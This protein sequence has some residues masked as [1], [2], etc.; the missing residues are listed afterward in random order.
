MEKKDYYD[1]L[2]LAHS[3]TKDDIKKAYRKLA[4]KYHPDKNKEKGA[5]EKFKEIS[6]AY[7]V[8]YDDEKRKMYDQYGHKGIDQQY[9]K[10][11]IF[12]TTD[13]GD[14]FR[15]TGFDFNDIFQQFFGQRNGFTQRQRPQRGSDIRYDIEI[16]LE[17]AYKGMETEL[18]VPRTELCDTCRGSGARPGSS[19]KRCP[20]CGGSGQ[21]QTSRRTAFGM[22]TQ[23]N[24]CPKCHGQGTFIEDPCPSCRGRGTQQKTRKIELRI[25]K[26]IED[27]A[28][29]RLTGQGEH[30]KGAVQ[31]GDLYVVV[32][33]KQHA[34][35]ERREADLYRKLDIS[36]PQASLGATLSVE[37]L[38]DS[39]TLKI[40]EGT[41]NGTI[42]KI[43][44]SGMPKIQGSG[45]GD[46]YVLIQV[47]T[48]KK[49]SKRAKLLLEE[50]RRELEY[51]DE[52]YK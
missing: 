32:H 34:V 18:E 35:F 3:A 11:D 41:E 6:E 28:H 5:E 17:D 45:Y 10:E 44:G 19:P 30:P 52:T 12:R 42:F 47:K 25:P 14:I 46:L 20:T 43:K 16:S 50:L 29:L 37:T 24:D 39:E 49:L 38:H 22:F 8:L 23:I 2:G 4:L 9:T 51:P 48:P 40:P 33:M 7:A 21:L 31:G 27:G 1:I 13:F 15:G 26:G 36:F